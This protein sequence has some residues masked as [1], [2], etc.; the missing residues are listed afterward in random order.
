[1]KWMM[2][3]CLLSGG[4]LLL[5]LSL[6]LI[7]SAQAVTKSEDIATT[8]ILRGQPCGGNTVRGISEIK[9]A[10]G[11][12]VIKATCPN[13]QRYRLDISS[14]GRVSVTPLR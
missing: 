2:K 10:A 3:K 8:I 7:P 1:M 5:L 6:P 12:T 13:G 14:D 11:N 4:M 9:D